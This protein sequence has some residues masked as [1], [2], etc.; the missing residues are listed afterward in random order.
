MLRGFSRVAISLKT[1][2]DKKQSEK[3]SVIFNLQFITASHLIQSDC[4][5]YCSIRWKFARITA[6][7]SL[8]VGKCSD[9]ES[10][11]NGILGLAGI[12]VK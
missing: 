3:E 12:G 6:S 9:D 8:Y 10:A 4:S 1:I 5:I 11:K 7:L 2:Y